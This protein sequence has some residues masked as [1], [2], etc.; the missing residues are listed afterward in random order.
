M[1][2]EAFARSGARSSRLSLEEVKEIVIETLLGTAITL[3]T[4]TDS[5]RGLMEKVATRGGMTEKGLEVLE[6]ELPA[7]FDRMFEATRAA[8]DGRCE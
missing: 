2:M 8:R 4:G 1:L 5:T 3:A 6:M 7:T